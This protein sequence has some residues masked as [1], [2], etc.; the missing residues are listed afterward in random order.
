ME[1]VEGLGI[2]GH[3]QVAVWMTQLLSEAMSPG[4]H[5]IISIVGR[6]V[7]R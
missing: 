2:I 5:W 4:R 6:E 1:V 7:E 3:F